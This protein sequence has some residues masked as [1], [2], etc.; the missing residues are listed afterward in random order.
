[1]A[2]PGAVKKCQVVR[3]VSKRGGLL[4]LRQIKIIF[5]AQRKNPLGKDYGDDQTSEARFQK[6]SV[7][8]HY[9]GRQR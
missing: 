1:M 2:F 6:K 8:S 9:S 4:Q 7:L 5:F 3:R